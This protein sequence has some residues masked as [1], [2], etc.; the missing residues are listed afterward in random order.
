MIGSVAWIGA[1]TGQRLWRVP[2]D[3]TAAGRPSAFFVGTYGRLR[4]AVA[5]PDGSLWLTTSNTDGRG[6]PRPGDDRILRVAVS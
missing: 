4:T 2:L 3:G 1:L 6:S 5:A